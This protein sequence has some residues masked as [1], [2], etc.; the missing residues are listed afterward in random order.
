MKNL[1]FVKGEI[2]CVKVIYLIFFLF[3]LTWKR[4]GWKPFGPFVNFGNFIAGNFLGGNIWLETFSPMLSFVETLWPDTV[5]PAFVS[6]IFRQEE[7]R[8]REIIT[9]ELLV[10]ACILKSYFIYA[11][12]FY[13]FFYY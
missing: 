4:F 13:I 12:S 6:Y 3:F 11:V 10:Y 5:W 1:D 2:K 8:N 7:Q 9:V